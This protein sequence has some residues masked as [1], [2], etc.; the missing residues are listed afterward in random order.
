MEENDD[1]Y[2]KRQGFA[3]PVY[4]YS[5]SFVILKIHLKISLFNNVLCCVSNQTAEER[6]CPAV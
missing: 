2:Y 3:I 4:M 5:Q 1:L 6:G